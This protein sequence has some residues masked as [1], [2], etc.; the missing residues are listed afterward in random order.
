MNQISS[1]CV[2][3]FDRFGAIINFSTKPTILCVCEIGTRPALTMSVPVRYSAATVILDNNN[4]AND[5]SVPKAEMA[6]QRISQEGRLGTP[7]AAGEPNLNYED[8]Q[9]IQSQQPQLHPPQQQ[10]LLNSLTPSSEEL[11][12]QL[13]EALALEKKYETNLILPTESQVSTFIYFFFIY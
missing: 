3:Q 2:K 1:D 4:C 12:A 6:K 9:H 10:Q 8:R 7:D 13:N 5:R 11:F